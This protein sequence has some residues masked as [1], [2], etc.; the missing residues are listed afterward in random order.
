MSIMNKAKSII[1]IG[2]GGHAK[3][4]IDIVKIMNLEVIGIT[5]NQKIKGDVYCGINI[6]GD[7]NAVFQYSPDDVYL[8]NA[9]GSLPGKKERT[10]VA[11]NFRKLCEE[12][13]R[14]FCV[15]CGWIDWPRWYFWRLLKRNGI[16][17]SKD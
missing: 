12:L 2:A 4:L 5:D 14:L 8:L 1:I 15:K 11:E 16:K 3:V 17:S 7:D 6:L 9:I 13:R 10:E